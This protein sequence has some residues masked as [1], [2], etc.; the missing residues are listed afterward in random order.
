MRFH[1][2]LHHSQTLFG[3][4]L[5]LRVVLNGLLY[6]AFLLVGGRLH[7]QNLFTDGIGRMRS[8]IQRFLRFVVQILNG[9]LQRNPA[10][11]NAGL[12]FS[13]CACKL[14]LCVGLAG[15]GGLLSASNRAFRSE[16]FLIASLESP[17]RSCLAASVCVVTLV[18]RD[19]RR[20]IFQGLLVL[21]APSA[22][23]L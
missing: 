20:Q 16:G 17:F 6:V 14:L 21:I 11:L 4:F 1:V 3:V 8:G 7:S 9:P 19:R 5:G 2:R 10:S 13:D 15:L 23:H 12:S 22:L 18:Q